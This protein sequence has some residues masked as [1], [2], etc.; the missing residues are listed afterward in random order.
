M[1]K[2]NRVRGRVIGALTATGV[3]VVLVVAYLLLFH[4]LRLERRYRD[5]PHDEDYA[6]IRR[7]R[8]WWEA[9]LMLFTIAVAIAGLILMLDGLTWGL[10]LH[11]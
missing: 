6:S 10:D 7:A 11:N 5:T 1:A 3:L 8:V 4:V 9:G 2:R